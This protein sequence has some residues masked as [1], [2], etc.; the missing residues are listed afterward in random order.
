MKNYILFEKT[1]LHT[2]V[3]RDST[4]RSQNLL[5]FRQQLVYLLWA[6][7]TVPRTKSPDFFFTRHL[8]E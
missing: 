5:A 7:A 3:V 8:I 1:S 4:I 6:V 2:L